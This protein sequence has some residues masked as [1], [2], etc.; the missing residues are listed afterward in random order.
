[1]GHNHDGQ[2]GQAQR[3]RLLVSEAGELV[4]RQKSRR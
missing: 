4:G 2:R 1:M 3:G